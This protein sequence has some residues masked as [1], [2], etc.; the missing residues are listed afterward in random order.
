MDRAT[1]V[2]ESIMF[3]SQ[4]SQFELTATQ[5]GIL[6]KKC[7]SKNLYISNKPLDSLIEKKI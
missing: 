7:C 5:R 4:R 1:V 3:I 2:D 6:P